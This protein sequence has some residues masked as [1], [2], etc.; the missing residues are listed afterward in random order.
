MAVGDEYGLTEDLYQQ[1][2]GRYVATIEVLSRRIVAKDQ[3]I[4][5]IETENAK[6]ENMAYARLADELNEGDV[7]YGDNPPQAPAPKR[8]K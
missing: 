4:A 2:I 5:K 7:Y 3:H 8:K 1:L 6:L